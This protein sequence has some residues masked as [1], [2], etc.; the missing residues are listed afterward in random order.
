MYMCALCVCVCVCVCE[1]VTVLPARHICG[2]VGYYDTSK[3]KRITLK[4]PL[5][6]QTYNRVFHKVS[7]T[8]DPIIRK[9]RMFVCIR[10]VLVAPSWLM[11]ARLFVLCCVVLMCLCV[12]VCLMCSLLRMGAAMSLQQTGF[13]LH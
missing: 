6:L 5:P 4:N 7:T 1:P 8:D 2:S 12:C 13:W 10:T 9:V 11:C 3:E